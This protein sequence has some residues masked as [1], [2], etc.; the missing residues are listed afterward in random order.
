MTLD[1]EFGKEHWKPGNVLMD[2]A[3]FYIARTDG[4]SILVSLVY[5]GN[6]NT[7][8]RPALPPPPPPTN[9]ARPGFINPV[10]D[11]SEPEQESIV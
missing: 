2:G 3:V 4:A 10:F 11:D 7:I 8:K 6:P 5:L 9:G 1:P